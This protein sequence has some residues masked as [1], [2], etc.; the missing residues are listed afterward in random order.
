MKN[1]HL[2]KLILLRNVKIIEILE[3]QTQI[4]RYYN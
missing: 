2:S 3:I 1:H 4:K